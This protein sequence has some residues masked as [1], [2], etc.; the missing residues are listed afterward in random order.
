[1]FLYELSAIV[2]SNVIISTVLLSFGVLLLPGME[3]IKFSVPFL[4]IGLI[5]GKYSFLSNKYKWSTVLLLLLFGLILYMLIWDGNEFIYITHSP[6]YFNLQLYS[7]RACVLR[8]ITGTLF[9]VSFVLVLHKVS[10]WFNIRWIA[11]LSK[12]SLGIYVT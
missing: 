2:F 6:N 9:T 10:G 8:F 5:M 3:Y 12:S 1:M 7:I 4:G 11:R